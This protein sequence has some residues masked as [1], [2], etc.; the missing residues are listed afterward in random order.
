MQEAAEVKAHNL[1][2]E[3]QEEAVLVETVE[4]IVSMQLLRQ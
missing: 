4:T 2:L 1:T 3:V